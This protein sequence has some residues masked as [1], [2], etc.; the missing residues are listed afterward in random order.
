MKVWLPIRLR[1]GRNE[2]RW[3]PGQ[4]TSLA[5]HIRNWGLPEAYVLQWRKCLWHCWDFLAAPQ[6]LGAPCTDL[7]PP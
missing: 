2:V 1:Q 5:P 3:R 6:P 4:E 7:A